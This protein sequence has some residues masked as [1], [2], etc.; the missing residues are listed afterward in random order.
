MNSGLDY[1]LKKVRMMNLSDKE[2]ENALNEVRILASIKNK[3]IIAYKEAF[4][5]EASSSLWSVKYFISQICIW[6]IDLFFLSIVMEFA[7]DGDL[8]QKICEHQKRGTFFS[9]NEIWSVFIQVLDLK[10]ELKFIRW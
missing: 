8:F 10:F 1:A 2:Q 6:K 3:N 7:D 9:E 5:D 4:V